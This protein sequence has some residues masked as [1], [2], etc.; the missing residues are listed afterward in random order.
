M[1]QPPVQRWRG[2]CAATALQFAMALR[3]D[4]FDTNLRVRTIMVGDEFCFQPSHPAL[5]DPQ[6]GA[7]LAAEEP[8]GAAFLLSALQAEY[9]VQDQNMSISALDAFFSHSRGALNMSD[10]LTMW[11]MTL[12]EADMLAGLQMNNVAKSYLLLRTSGLPERAKDDLKMHIQYDLSRFDELFGLMQRMSTRDSAVA[13]S[14]V[15]A[16]SRQFWT[17]DGW[18]SADQTEAWH[19]DDPLHNWYADDPAEGYDYD[20]D[21]NHDSS[22]QEY[23]DEWPDEDEEAHEEDWP[24]HD[25]YCGKGKDRK[26]AGK[27]GRRGSPK[28]GIFADGCTMRGSKYHGVADCPLGRTGLRHRQG[29][30]RKSQRQAQRKERQRKKQGLREAQG[31][32]ERSRTTTALCWRLRP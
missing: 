10:Y 20:A 24:A 21:W 6:T 16:M 17:D 7:L 8:A 12:E 28:R 14:S 18:W 31:A 29:R 13:S 22:W 30:Q 2:A 9:G 25:D 3:A 19:E 26:G 27:K 15:P 5:V 11:K 4:R 1:R 32:T 23:Y